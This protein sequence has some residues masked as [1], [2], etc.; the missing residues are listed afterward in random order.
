MSNDKGAKRKESSFISLSFF[1]MRKK[2]LDNTIYKWR[3]FYESKGIKQ[4]LIDVYLS[5]AQNLL[6]N[7]API[8]FDFEHLSLLLRL[9][10]DLLSTLVNAPDSFYRQ[11]FIPK[12]SGGQREIT[13]PYPSLKYVQTWINEKV[14]SKVPLHGCAHG[15]VDRRSI[16]TNVEPHL[17][18]PCLLKIDLKDF[19]P[20]ITINMVIQVFKS[21]GYTPDVS[22]YLASMCCYEGVL[23]QGSPASPAISNIVAKHLDRRLY[24][25]GKRFGYTYTRYADDIAFSG[26]EIPVAFIKYVKDIVT[27]CGFAINEKKVRL[28]GK[29]GNKILTGISVA[30]GKPRIP[31]DYRRNLE[32]ELFYIK[33]YGIDAHMNH[34]KIRRYNYIESIIGRVNFWRMVEPDNKLAIEM[35]AYLRE[36]HKRKKGSPN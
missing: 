35:S 28:Y 12:R 30:S 34:M 2:E 31:R 16:L 22:F 11:F 23:P 10:R 29:N 13:A 5:Y 25:L 9:N 20:S 6:K 24:R 26:E 33:K 15:F 8:I 27:D 1:V 14:L 7:N 19:F 36:E 32:K 4:E 21:L 18:K 17:G 3:K